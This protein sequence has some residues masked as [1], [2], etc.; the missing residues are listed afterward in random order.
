LTSSV[1]LLLAEDEP[2][3]LTAAQDALE[4]GGYQVLPAE[5]GSEAMSLLEGNIEELAGI[6]TDIR[7][8]AGPSGWEVARH[9]RSLNPN[10]PIVYTSGDSA[11][12]WP[13]EGVPNSVMVQ[14]PYAHAQVLTAISG[15]LNAVDGTSHD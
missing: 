7:L 4:A 14:K 15:L 8:G 2:L 11:H 3:I 5:T 13:V 6:V 9:A 10:L 12:E 1:L